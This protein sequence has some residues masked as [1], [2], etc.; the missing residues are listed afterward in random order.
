MFLK[1]DMKTAAWSTQALKVTA[2]ISCKKIQ[3]GI[4][5]LSNLVITEQNF[6]V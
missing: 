2:E 1:K 6:C 3:V 4:C 5:Q